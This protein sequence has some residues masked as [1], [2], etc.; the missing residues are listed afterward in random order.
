MVEPAPTPP[1]HSHVEV[2]IREVERAYDVAWQ[3]GD[4]EGL[5]ACLSPDAVLI[6][7][8]GGVAVGHDEIRR[9]LAE[10]L[11]GPAASQR[12]T[13]ILTRVTLV[14]DGVAVVDGEVVLE[15][16]HGE[17]PFTHRLTDV[18]VKRDEG[19]RVAHIRAYQ[20]LEPPR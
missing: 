13:S 7:P 14:T 8:F 1:D 3:D 16:T 17:T 20:H 18:L 5:L 6:N 2:A 4:L 19:W 15:G 12:H 11:S 10:V 9:E